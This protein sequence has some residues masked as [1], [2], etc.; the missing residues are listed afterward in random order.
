MSMEDFYNRVRDVFLEEGAFI[1][2]LNVERSICFD[3]LIHDNNSLQI[4][5]PISKQNDIPTIAKDKVGVTKF[6]VFI[7]N[8]DDDIYHCLYVFED[9]EKFILIIYLS[10]TDIHTRIDESTLF[11]HEKLLLTKDGYTIKDG[12]SV[13]NAIDCIKNKYLVIPPCKVD[14][15]FVIKSYKYSSNLGYKGCITIDKDLNGK[16]SSDEEEGIYIDITPVS[17]LVLITFE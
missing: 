9:D 4:F 12:L 11:L 13:D 3:P 8:Y 5:M 2:G 15:D 14:L 10:K 16:I 7:E 6:N 1:I 17:Q